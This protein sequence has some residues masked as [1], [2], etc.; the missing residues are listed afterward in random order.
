MG[1]GYQA[2]GM[3]LAQQRE[4]LAKVLGSVQTRLQNRDLARLVGS[5]IGGTDTP[6]GFAQGNLCP[7][8]LTLILIPRSMWR[9][10]PSPRSRHIMQAKA[11]E[12]NARTRLQW[13]T[14]ANFP[15]TL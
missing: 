3:A 4:I 8:L 15:A 9:G 11:N 5:E 2:W 6:F 7:S 12:P 13:Q 14:R 10:R 1:L